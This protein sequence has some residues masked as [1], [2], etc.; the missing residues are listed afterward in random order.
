MPAGSDNTKEILDAPTIV[1]VEDD[2]GVRAAYG[3]LICSHGLN[4]RL[5]ASAEDFLGSEFWSPDCVILDLRLPGISGLE[6]QQKLNELNWSV[7]I[8][9]VTSQD[10]PAT[11]RKAMAGG[12]RFFFGKPVDDGEMIWIDAVPH[13]KSRDHCNEDRSFHLCPSNPSG[14]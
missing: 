8:I 6:L 10:D 9:F 1:V 14:A 2:D 5:Y 13:A 7:P 4:S 12:A 3:D 11:R